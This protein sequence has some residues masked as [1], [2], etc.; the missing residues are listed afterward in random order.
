MAQG[1]T[2]RAYQEVWDATNGVWVKQPLVM[3][4]SF[5][6]TFSIDAF[7]RSRVSTPQTL[8]DSKQTHDAGP[9]VWDDTQVSGTATSTFSAY[10]ASSLLA[11]NNL[12]AGRRVRQTRKRFNYQPGKSQLILITFVLGGSKVGVTKNVGYFDDSNGIFLQHKDGEAYLI[13]R[14][15]VSGTPS[16]TDTVA[17]DDWN[18]DPMDGS[19]PSGVLLD[20]TKA[21]ILYIDMEWLGVG[22][23]RVGFVVDG[24]IHYVH[25][26]VHSN[27]IASVY[28]SDPNLPI[29]YELVGTDAQTGDTLE[30][31][32]SS[33]MS[34][35]G[36]SDTAFPF[37]AATQTSFTG[38]AGTTYALVGLRKK[39]THISKVV[40]LVSASLLLVSSAARSA[41][42]SLRLNPTVAGTAGNA[43]EGKFAD[44]TNSALQA[45]LGVIANTVTGG[46][47]LSS[48]F[49][50]NTNSQTLAVE[51]LVSLGTTLAGVRD[52]IVLTATPIGGN[53]DLWGALNWKEF[54]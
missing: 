15:N 1:G 46:T 34:E 36:I 41:R 49:A 27:R 31:I 52:Q 28:M 25:Q 33:V 23:V 11:V 7:G 18:L 37:S 53:A 19:G 17:Q 42:Y 35:G 30:C 24:L 26:F 43:W 50:D 4:T 16:D 14:T 12:T 2:V 13:R 40:E 8:F 32:C 6:D 38:V 51:T 21:Q 20:W 44:V 47:I 39:T 9:L 45:A 5:S 54:A 22:R 48:A 10:R 3:P 29:R